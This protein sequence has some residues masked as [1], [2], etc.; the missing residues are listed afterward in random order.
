MKFAVAVQHV[1]SVDRFLSDFERKSASASAAELSGL[2]DRLSEAARV[3]AGLQNYMK[4][5]AKADVHLRPS[6]E[7]ISACCRRLRPILENGGLYCSA[8][9]NILSIP[10]QGYVPPGMPL[11]LKLHGDYAEEI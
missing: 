9:L 8:R 7:S 4:Q 11:N 5:D 3:L 2:F 1:Q 6:L 10:I